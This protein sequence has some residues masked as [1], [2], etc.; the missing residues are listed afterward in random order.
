MHCRFGYAV[1]NVFR[2]HNSIVKF[3]LENPAEPATEYILPDGEFGTEPLFIPSICENSEENSC[4]EDDGYVVV[5]TL[6]AKSGKSNIL[7]LWAK[8]MKVEFKASAPEMGL[9]GLHSGFFP[10]DVGCSKD[11]CIPQQGSGAS[12]VN[13]LSLFILLVFLH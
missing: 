3:D 6:D 8:N 2:L 4:E 11:S 13:Y 10:F 12:K 7:V 1:K 9:F 5:N